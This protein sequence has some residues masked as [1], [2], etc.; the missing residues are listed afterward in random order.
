MSS[1]RIVFVCETAA[2]E[3][4]RSADAIAKLDDRHRTRDVAI[5]SCRSK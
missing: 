1:R 4:L 3:S 5:T 2:G